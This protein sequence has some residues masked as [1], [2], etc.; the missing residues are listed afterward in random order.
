MT[1][2]CA[3][4]CV[5]VC[6][7]VCMC[8]CVRARECAC[9]RVCAD[10]QGDYETMCRQVP[11]EYGVTLQGIF[12]WGWD[13]CAPDTLM[14]ACVCLFVSLSI[15]HKR[16]LPSALACLW[17]DST[18]CPTISLCRVW[19]CS[20]VR[21]ESEPNASLVHSGSYVAQPEEEEEE[22]EPRH[23]SERAA[24]THKW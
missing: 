17:A 19:F 13:R 20:T 24:R 23:V 9:A 12:V 8:V 15:S 16:A 7:H 6:M 1:S 11:P 2:V 3:C 21:H 4:V 5:C 18:P 14:C 10:N 22:E